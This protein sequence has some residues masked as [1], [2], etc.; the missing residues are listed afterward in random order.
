MQATIATLNGLPLAIRRWKKSR[1]TGFRRVATN[2]AM[3]NAQRTVGKEGDLLYWLS[4]KGENY[5]HKSSQRI[6]S[7]DRVE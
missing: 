3:Y 7:K 4:I 2:V 5:F 6:H 1:I